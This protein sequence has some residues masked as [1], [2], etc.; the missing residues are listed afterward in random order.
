MGRKDMHN[1]R[2]GY[3]RAGTIMGKM[4][5]HNEVINPLPPVGAYVV[6]REC[7]IHVTKNAE[8]DL[9]TTYEDHPQYRDVWNRPKKL[10]VMGYTK[11]IEAAL[12]PDN[13]I[14]LD[15]KTESGM[16]FHHQIPVI[17][18]STGS[19]YLTMVEV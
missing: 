11:G 9:Y 15:W 19:L 4:R 1:N 2:T 17:Q 7:K 8:T 5:E 3:R 16:I 12:D 6:V 18:V 13:R 10:L 14:L